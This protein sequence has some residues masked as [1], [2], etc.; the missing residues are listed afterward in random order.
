MITDP[1]TTVRSKL[2]QCV[3]V[4]VIALVEMLMRLQQIV[5]A[6]FYALFMVG[7][8]AMLI[9]IWMD[10]RRARTANLAAH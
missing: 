8:T 10:S 9:E 5:Y 3:V 2:W 1:K 6:P 4:F 7:P